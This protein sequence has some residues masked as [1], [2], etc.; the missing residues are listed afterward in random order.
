MYQKLLQGISRQSG[1]KTTTHFLNQ[2]CDLES[3]NCIRKLMKYESSRNKLKKAQ[4]AQEI[5]FL[6]NG[7]QILRKCDLNLILSY[8]SLLKH[9][10]LQNET[11][12][13]SIASLLWKWRSDEEE[14]VRQNP[15]KPCKL[16]LFT[17]LNYVGTGGEAITSQYL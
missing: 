10:V 11:N 6:L 13:K 5:R 4:K 8:F 17:V 12:R 9:K 2:S 16:C 1:Q 7:V 3:E 14:G 15:S